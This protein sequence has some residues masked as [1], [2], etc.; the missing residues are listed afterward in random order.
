MSQAMLLVYGWGNV[1]ASI[2]FA[3]LWLTA[4]RFGRLGE[5][6]T[7]FLWATA[8]SAI[9]CGLMAF[10]LATNMPSPV[11][12]SLAETLRTASW[13]LFL[14]IILARSWRW[15]MPLTYS[16]VLMFSLG[17][18]LMVQ[19]AVDG[20]RLAGGGEL[21]TAIM[22][23]IDGFSIFSHLFVAIGGMLL[24][25]NLFVN[26]EPSQ[27]WGVGLLCIALAALFIFDFNLYLFMLMGRAA[28][29]FLAAR[30]I[31]NLMAVP[32]IALSLKRDRV[33]KFDLRLSRQAVFTSLSLVAVGGYLVLIAAGFYVLQLLH[34]NLAALLQ[35]ILLFSA[36]ILLVIL[37]FSGRVRGW[38]RV[39][40]SKHFFA[41][42]YDYRTEWLRFIA[43]IGGRQQGTGS[44]HERVIKA[45]GDIV[46]SP[47]GT[48]WLPGPGDETMFV[49]GARW[50]FRTAAQGAEAVSGPFVKFLSDR[51][52]IV[53]FDELRAGLGDYGGLTLPDWAHETTKSWLAIP[54]LHGGKLSGFLVLE[55]P[56][57]A[58]ALNWEDFD[59]LK[60]IGRQAASYLA[61]Q[62]SQKALLEAQQFD[63][64]NRRFAFIMHDIKNLVSQLSLIS[65]NA[66][67]HADNPVFQKD[68]ML[69]VR[70][71]VTKMNELLARLGQHHTGR[72]ERRSVDLAGLIADA[73][74]SK[75]CQHT[76]LHFVNNTQG[77]VIETDVERLEQVVQHLLQNAI[78]AC[79]D[80]DITV[81]LSGPLNGALTIEIADAGKGMSEDFIM[82]EL[83][84]PFRSTKSGGF[85]IGA[86]EAREIVR[87]LGGKLSV[88]S[89]TGQGTVFR[90]LL[91]SKTVEQA[92]A[93]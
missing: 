17:L 58:H 32:L 56:R 71:S 11:L 33:W 75:S 84:T 59:L 39:K 68:V 30:G 9:W 70:D 57:A 31:I 65:R 50:N 13:I 80:K 12:L 48:L 24:V 42:K 62:A 29:S 35:I 23:T 46:D 83:F 21:F 41:Y 74:K 92:V 93:A 66:E 28:D 18:V 20:L 5:A 44:L 78:D 8:M 52:R 51:Q 36:T 43:T 73:L 25:H 6:G 26:V 16:L 91:P 86:Y 76:A 87:T 61:E 82:N 4:L 19:V 10:T 40:I 14:G 69:T 90:I 49:V 89:C 7:A 55:H 15:G 22:S 77:A 37:A 85:G 64:F 1:G 53:N 38:I 79:P 88:E 47:G 72:S 2:G 34:G 60:T 63:A 54:L 27:R 45:V 81:R 67:V 3:I